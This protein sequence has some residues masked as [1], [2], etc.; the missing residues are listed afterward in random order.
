[1][2]DLT[3]SKLLILAIVALLVVG[4][5]DFPLLLRT[6]GKYLGMI[7]RQAAEFRTQFNEAI[8]E[9]EM[10]ELRKELQS[11]SEQVETTMR[12]GGAAIDS[13]MHEAR[14]SID[15]ALGDVSVTGDY[16]AIGGSARLDPPTTDAALPPPDDPV[17]SGSET[18]P[19]PDDAPRVSEKT[20]T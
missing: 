10:Q 20:G 14:D 2:F 19:A 15:S 17:P 9:A 4:P 7:R 5:K 13:S 8:N 12:E 6:V 1:M 18:E 11:V 3:S 16:G